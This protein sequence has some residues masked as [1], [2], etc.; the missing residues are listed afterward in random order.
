MFEICSKLKI[1]IPEQSHQNDINDV[2]LLSLLLTLSR[3]SVSILTIVEQINGGW[4]S[5]MVSIKPI[6]VKYYFQSARK[7]F[8]NKFVYPTLGARFLL[9]IVSQIELNLTLFKWPELILLCFMHKYGQTE[10]GKKVKARLLHYQRWNI[11]TAE[12]LHKH[13]RFLTKHR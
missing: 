6:Y 12:S 2:L 8:S 11:F 4:E 9:K 5:V 3:F 7:I 10:S 13:S 1:K